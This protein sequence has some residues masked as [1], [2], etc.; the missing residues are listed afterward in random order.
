MNDS[1]QPVIAIQ[2][3]VCCFPVKRDLPGAVGYFWMEINK[4]VLARSDQCDFSQASIN[5]DLA[6]TLRCDCS[7]RVSRSRASHERYPGFLLRYR[8]P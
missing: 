6:R 2:L 1:D 7:I 3:Y 4:L 5:H 8:S